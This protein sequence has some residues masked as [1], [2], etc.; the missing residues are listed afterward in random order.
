MVA[1][2]RVR[3]RQLQ[4]PSGWYDAGRG[5]PAFACRRPEIDRPP[6]QSIRYFI[7][8]IQ[9]KQADFGKRPGRPIDVAAVLEEDGP[10]TYLV[11][12]DST[13]T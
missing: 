3:P 12:E 7:M 13:R 8:W 10:G 2:S 1:L 11:V 6:Q 9:L 4:T 5:I